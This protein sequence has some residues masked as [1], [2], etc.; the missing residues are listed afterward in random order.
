M[1]GSDLDIEIT[2]TIFFLVITWNGRIWLVMIKLFAFPDQQLF[3]GKSSENGPLLHLPV[4]C[5]L[6]MRYCPQSCV[7]M[8]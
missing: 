6:S 1:D 5:H 2:S 8:W 4:I 3:E 7:Q